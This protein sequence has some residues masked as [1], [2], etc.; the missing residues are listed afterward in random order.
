[1]IFC[2]TSTLAKYYVPEPETAVVQ[3]CLDG[4]DQVVASE[5]ARAELMAV[6]HRRFREG[7]WTNTEIQAAVRQFMQDETAS[8]WTWVPLDSAIVETSVRT[9]ATL[10]KKIYLR[11]AD[12]LH[13]ITAVY[14]HFDEIYTHDEHQQK[15]ASA[16][17]LKFI[18]IGK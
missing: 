2:D 10:P 16:F 9:F 13:L 18:N 5:L 12:C 1:M 6:F 17:G 14:H 7:K 11:T 3:S 15:A 4:E 8:Y